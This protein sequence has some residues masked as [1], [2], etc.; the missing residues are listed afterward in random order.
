MGCALTSAAMVMAYYDVDTNPKRLNDA[1]G[2]GGYDVTYYIYGSAVRNACHDKTNRIEY[3][4][5]RIAPFDKT[6]LSTHLDLGRP[7]IGDIPV[8]GDCDDDGDDNI[9]LYRPGSTT[10]AFYLNI[11][12]DGGSADIVT[13]EYRDLGD[14]SIAGDWDGDSDDNVG[15]YRSGTEEFFMDASLPEVSS[16]KT[17]YVDD[18]FD[19]NPSGHSW[20]TIQEGVDDASDGDT[21][22]VYAGTYYENVDVNK[23][24][25]LV[26]EDKNTTFV[27]G[28]GSVDVIRVTSDG[29]T[30]SGFTIQ[31]RG[32]SIVDMVEIRGEIATGSFIWTPVNFAGFYYD[33]DADVGNETFTVVTSGRT[34]YEGDMGYKT[35]PDMIDFEYSGWG[36]YQVIGFMTEKYFAGYDGTETDNEIT[37]D[38]ISLISNNILIKVLIDDDNDHAILHRCI[39]TVSGGI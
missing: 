3:D 35:T 12:N 5:G 31:S 23:R 1:I 34:V 14:V 20:D 38:G 8:A 19:D 36:G 11:D 33:I 39:T 6:V 15:V 32:S 10:G 16:S 21:V 27:S 7:V 29:C 37:E 26:G 24:I 13:L 2:R 28:V 17:I 4:P 9:G 22:I 25:S 18:D 30:I